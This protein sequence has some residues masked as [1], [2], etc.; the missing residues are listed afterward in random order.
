MP[1]CLMLFDTARVLQPQL[2]AEGRGLASHI[3]G[4]VPGAALSRTHTRAAPSRIG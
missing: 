2:S 4:A 1:P 3:G